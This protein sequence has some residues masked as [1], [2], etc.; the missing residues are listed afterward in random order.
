MYKSNINAICYRPCHQ[1]NVPKN[2]GIDVLDN[3]YKIIFPKDTMIGAL[4]EYISSPNE[5]FQPMNSNFGILPEYPEKIKDK[6]KK[7]EKLA[8]RAIDS[9]TKLL[10]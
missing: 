1:G 5:H 7:Y 4:A 2:V 3:P 6:Q 10:Q 9:I 8:N